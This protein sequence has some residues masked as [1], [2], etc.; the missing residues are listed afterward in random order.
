MCMITVDKRLPT[1]QV[2]LGHPAVAVAQTTHTTWPDSSGSHRRWHTGRQHLLR[3]PL[4]APVLEA[5]LLQAH[6]GHM[7]AAVAAVSSCYPVRLDPV[8]GYCSSPSAWH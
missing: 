2:G 1:R 8:V 5:A 7:K 3:Q 4:P 6:S